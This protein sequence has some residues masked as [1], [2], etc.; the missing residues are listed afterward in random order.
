LLIFDTNQQFATDTNKGTLKT[1]DQVISQ[2]GAVAKSNGTGRTGASQLCTDWM[3]ELSG[4]ELPVPLISYQNV[5]SLPVSFSPS[6]LP[7]ANGESGT[8]RKRPCSLEQAEPAVRIHSA[9]VRDTAR[10]WKT[11]ANAVRSHR[12]SRGARLRSAPT[13]AGRRC[14]VPNL[15]G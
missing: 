8:D 11:V 4:F 10:S 9:T 5:R 12:Y 3:V 14:P 15:S 1:K 7:G 6:A 2:K 13:P